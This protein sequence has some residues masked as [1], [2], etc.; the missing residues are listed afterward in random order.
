MPKTDL[1]RLDVRAVDAA[2]IRRAMTLKELGRRAGICRATL[3][4][5]H[6]GRSVSLESARAF[7]KA[8]GVALRSLLAA[9]AVGGHGAVEDEGLSGFLGGGK[10]KCRTTPHLEQQR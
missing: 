10:G 9:P 8:L 4:V 6:A 2:R 3:Y 1:V 7:A 5:M